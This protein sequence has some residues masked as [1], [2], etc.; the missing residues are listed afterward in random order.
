MKNAQMLSCSRG[1]EIESI[2]DM[3]LEEH[4]LETSNWNH[5]YQT[6]A[7]E[8]AHTIQMQSRPHLMGLEQLLTDRCNQNCTYKTD[9]IEIAPAS[10][11]KHTY[12][13]RTI[14]ET[15]NYFQKQYN[16]ICNILFI[17]G[18]DS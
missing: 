6:D 12:K 8:I 11:N 3:Q 15:V 1:V 10:T 5:T 9:V 14:T 17:L 18:G 13:T 7:I 2:R 4:L 16:V